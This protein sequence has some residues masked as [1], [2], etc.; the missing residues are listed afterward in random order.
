MKDCLSDE[1]IKGLYH[2]SDYKFKPAHE[3]IEE[4]LGQFQA[5]FE[6]RQAEIK[7]LST[8]T[9]NISPFQHQLMMS[10]RRHPHYIFLETDKGLGPAAYWRLKYAE[11][12]CAEHLGNTVNYQQLTPAQAQVKQQG[13]HRYIFPAWLNKFYFEPNCRPPKNGEVAISKAEATF[14]RRA[15]KKYPN[16]FARFRMSMKVHKKS[17]Q[18]NTPF[19]FRPIGCCVGTF[20]NDW[21]RW[22]DW[23][24]QA[25]KPYIE[26]YLQ[27]G[28]QLI[29]ELQD[30]E[31]GPNDFLFTADANS[32]YTNIDTDHAIK[33]ISLLLD[34]LVP[35]LPIDFPINAIKEAM[36]IIM[37]NHL[38]EWGALYFLQLL[39]TA[40]GTSAAV[41]WATLYY[42]YHEKT[43][44]LPKYGNYLRYYKR[45]IDDMFGIWRW[46]GELAW[47]EFCKDVDNFGIL[48]WDIH[49]PE[50]RPS[51]SV[52]F[53]DLTISIVDGKIEFKTFQKDLNLYL[54]LPPS[55]SHPK[56][57][58]KGTIYS[59]V[60]RYYRQNTHRKDFLHIVRLFFNHL[61]DRG[62]K[63]D[64][65]KPIFMEACDRMDAKRNN[66]TLTQSSTPTLAQEEE[67]ELYIHLQHHDNDITRR[68]I[69]QLYEKY[70]G[71]IFREHLGVK[72]PTI[73]YSRAPNIGDYLTQAKWH[74]HPEKSSTEIMGEYRQGLEP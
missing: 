66:N 24:L 40:M 35:I 64:D 26:S 19:K 68:E 41:M 70:C 1:Y 30:F 12:V 65:I 56:S 63:A 39:G 44:L 13:L 50:R 36:E 17:A 49:A 34:E 72:R 69:Q 11:R 9:P 37:K 20:I 33:V 43:C 16:K 15:L 61:L 73:A 28:F 62:W 29:D 67:E 5:A 23:Q 47:N 7:T 53:L 74:E 60:G 4:A 57:T 8:V 58:I 21:S 10:L 2:K 25:L 18:F 6:S 32:M 52:D 22:L 55:S 54:Y 42:W 71:P 59:L 14:L 31:L 38:F 48:T 27:D 46:D 3:D 51:P 45:F